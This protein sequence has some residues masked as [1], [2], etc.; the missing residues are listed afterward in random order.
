MFIN[1]MNAWMIDIAP[2]TQLLLE[3]IYISNIFALV[4]LQAVMTVIPHE[5][6]RVVKNMSYI[7]I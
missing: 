6:V 3:H 1:I 2:F 5:S 7:G 4:S